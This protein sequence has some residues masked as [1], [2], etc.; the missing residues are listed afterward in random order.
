M[1]LLTV[2]EANHSLGFVLV[3][4][5]LC[6]MGAI[7][8]FS[9]VGRA[10]ETRAPSRNG[11][12]VLAALC[13]GS[14]LWATHFMGLLGYAPAARQGFATVTVFACM[15]VAIAGIGLALL[16]AT[17]SAK[18]SSILIGGGLLG[19]SIVSLHAIALPGEEIE[20]IHLRHSP[21]FIAS[22]VLPILFGILAVASM[23]RW[24]NGYSRITPIACLIAA[25]AS[26]HIAGVASFEN[27]LAPGSTNFGT[28]D[29]E[30]LILAV[31]LVALFITGGSV[32]LYM[33]EDRVGLRFRERLPHSSF[34][35]SLTG[36]PNQRA[37]QLRIA[38]A[39]QVR[40]WFK[41]LLIDV[42]HFKLV[43]D[44]YG[45]AVGDAVLLSMS[46]R[47]RE[48]VGEDATAFR[49]G[50]DELAI[51]VFENKQSALQMAD[52][53]VISLR[54]PYAV[55]NQMVTLGCSVGLCASDNASNAVEVIHHAEIALH[56]AK[57]RGRNQISR[58]RHG[59]ES[60][61]L[62]RT[63]REMDLK[64][65]IDEKQFFLAY[66]P[67]VDIRDRKP[68]G[69]EALIRWKHPEEGLVSPA[70][71]VPLAEETGLI[72]PLGKWVLE[73]A[74]R[75]AASWPEDL[76]VAVNVSALQFRSPALLSHVTQALERSGLP[77]GRLE[78][79]L[80]ETAIVADGKQL[81]HV[82]QDLRALGVKIAM[83]D[84]G[85]GYSSL[86][87][88]RD[89]PLDRVKIDRSFVAAAAEDRNSMAVLRA[90]TQLGRDM[91]IATLG[92]GVET[93]EQFDILEQL[94]C[95]AVQGYLTGRPEPRRSVEAE[96]AVAA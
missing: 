71:F 52:D 54:S 70:E 86:S 46:K 63:K 10:L 60:A 16:V 50:G 18:R 20:A 34:Q 26:S 87:H 41:L 30:A 75:E 38:E 29:R 89:L 1:S 65:A 82:L 11:W 68:I 62:E 84:F 90:V 14:T 33:I 48:I 92:E 58:Y 96:P 9:L 31:G 61:G 2:L 40:R 80:T 51:L 94:G 24:W 72:V 79:E 83:D 73:E 66:Q 6:G 78:L 59:M 21:L 28:V 95:D 81:A 32:S 27:P 19:L 25:V 88:L 77:A 76:H 17:H 45:S 93:E 47:L 91:G 57:L 22:V 3:A 44:T 23:H 4:V 42:D 12:L 15:F 5:T 85:T 56:D 49:I 7:V 67:V 55:E 36:L 53:V 35:D 39:Y 64:T 74:C 8:A 37:L 13:G 43:N 69:F